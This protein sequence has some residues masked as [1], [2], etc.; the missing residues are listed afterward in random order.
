MLL[1]PNNTLK[2]LAIGNSFSQ[3]AL[4][5][6]YHIAQS[7]GLEQIVLAN[8]YIGGC[9][10]ETHWNNA[11]HNL[12]AYSYDKN[13]DGTWRSQENQTILH[14]LQD[15][16]WDIITFQQVSGL[17]GIDSSYQEDNRLTNLINYV[18]QHKT[19]PHLKLA[20]HM[21][22]AYQQDC[23]KESFARYNND[24]L[25]MY[26]AIVRATQREIVNNEAF[27]FLIPTGTA[28]QNVRTS[29]L[30]DTLTRDGYHLSLNLGRYIA[31]LTWFRVLTGQPIEQITYVPHRGE[32]P[33]RSLPIIKKAV[34]Y[35]MQ[36]PF[37][38]TNLGKG[39]IWT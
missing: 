34:N 1:N 9:S 22:W 7:A 36:K 17:S 37:V 16:A 24:Q 15:E 35:A 19:N 18:H 11:K 13:I 23:T 29:Y 21:T 26:R 14:G 20:W 6:L 27:S 30:G 5:H 10:L 28:I 38:I 8:L 12:A 33:P 25:T 3:D 31:G 39:E 32:V 4:E 2:V